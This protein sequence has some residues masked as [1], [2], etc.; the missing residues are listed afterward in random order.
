MFHYTR[1]MAQ[2]NV[3]SLLKGISANDLRQSLLEPF[4]S[5]DSAAHKNPESY[6]A[7]GGSQQTDGDNSSKV[8]D[9]HQ[10]D[11]T[12]LVANMHQLRGVDAW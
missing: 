11:E 8:A 5:S 1:M 2:M 12:S 7:T 6:S 10:T 9:V 3:Q 4:K